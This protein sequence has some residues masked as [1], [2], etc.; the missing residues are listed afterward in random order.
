MGIF[1]SV[2]KKDEKARQEIEALLLIGERI[3]EVYSLIIDYAAVT[4]I[5]LIFVDRNATSSKKQVTSIP[6]NKISSVHL[7]KG[8]FLSWTKKVSVHVSSKEYEIELIDE[9]NAKE[10]HDM[11]LQRII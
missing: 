7:Q 5:R 1:K 3:E 11:I 10:L 6:W 9:G 8:G 4:S 2:E